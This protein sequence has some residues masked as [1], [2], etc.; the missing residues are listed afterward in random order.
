MAVAAG[1]CGPGSGPLATDPV[2]LASPPRCNRPRLPCTMPHCA[3]WQWG[4][5]IVT[6]PDELHY[7]VRRKL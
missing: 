6:H 1:R 2:C 7:E 3:A 4:I 5:M